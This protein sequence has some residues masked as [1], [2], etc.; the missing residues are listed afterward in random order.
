MVRRFVS[1]LIIASAMSSMLWSCGKPAPESRAP[2]SVVET[3][4]PEM[5]KAMAEG[6][7]T[8]REIVTQYLTRIGLY[9]DRLNA[10]ASINA[11][12]LA[13]ADA[14]DRERAAGKVRGPLHGIPVALKDNILT[15]DDLPTTGGMLAFKHYMAPYDAT[16]VTQLKNAGAIILAKST[17]SE[18]AGWFGDSFRPGGYNGAAGQSYNPYDPRAND[19]G[20]PVLE[21]SGFQFR[22][23]RRRR[24][25]G[26]KRRH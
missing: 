6:R 13:Q 17:M 16:L 12:A 21:N 2:F 23:R 5:Q 20:T 18:L 4:I 9:E 19:D 15:K 7:T 1:M 11:N 10:A 26:G 8:S 24:P 25:V 3:S 22:R 14:L